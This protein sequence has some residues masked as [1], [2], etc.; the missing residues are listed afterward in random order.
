MFR[1]VLL[2]MMSLAVFGLGRVA[3]AAKAAEASIDAGR[4][5]SV[6]K[7]ERLVSDELEVDKSAL[8]S[9]SRIGSIAES[10][11]SMSE[12]KSVRYLAIPPQADE[13]PDDATVSSRGPSDTTASGGGRGG[14]LADAI[15]AA[16]RMAAGEAQLLLVGDVGLASSR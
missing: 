13:R 14:S 3:I 11:M 1:G 10:T 7:Q 12:A 9:P 5:K 8:S 6:I 4:L 16:M 2:A 15:A